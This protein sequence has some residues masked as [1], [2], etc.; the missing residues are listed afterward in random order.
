M[1]FANPIRASLVFIIKSV[2]AP[3]F[4]S[5]L[6]PNKIIKNIN[7]LILFLNGEKKRLIKKLMKEKPEKVL[8]LKHIQDV[9]LIDNSEFGNWN[10]EIGILA[11][12]VEAY[13][14]SH[15]A[16]KETFGAMVVFNN[17]MENK[18]SI[19]FLKIKN[20]PPNDDLAALVEMLERRL[21]H[22]EWPF[23]DL[24]VIDGGRPQVLAVSRVLRNN[25]IKIPM[26]GISK[27]QNDKLIFPLGAKKTFQELAEASKMFCFAPATK[28]IALPTLPE[29][30]EREL[31]WGCEIWWNFNRKMP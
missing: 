31:I 21:K 10:L 27:L 5:G 22:Q 16:G 20:A 17:G 2:Y 23:P 8:I 3:A 29:K 18:T 13:D 1:E 12:R 6:F 19:G 7:N 9:S 25:N 15:F 14:I 24:I 26:L 4:A 11:K 30:G 28:P